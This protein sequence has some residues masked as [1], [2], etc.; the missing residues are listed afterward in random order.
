MAG[1]AAALLD[2]LPRKCRATIFYDKAIVMGKEMRRCK[3]SSCRLRMCV[4]QLQLH[5][6]SADLLPRAAC[7]LELELHVADQKGLKPPLSLQRHAKQLGMHVDCGSRFL[8]YLVRREG[9]CFLG[10]Y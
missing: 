6:T 4:L 3:T 7:L 9:T 8:S 2:G 10:Q 5:T 1:V